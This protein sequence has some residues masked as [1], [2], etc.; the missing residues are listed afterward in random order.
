MTDTGIMKL[1]GFPPSPNTW[2]VRAV[3]A[4]LGVPI[5]NVLVDLGKGEQRAPDYLA[6]NPTG[7][8]PTL[9]DGD[10]VLWESAAIMQYLASQRPN[11]LWPDDV[12]TRADVMRWQSWHLQH[13]TAT[14][15]TPLL[16][17]CFVKR[18]F[19]MGAPDSAIVGRA[20]E[21][22][23]R[24]AAVLDR[25][26]STR[27]YLVGAGVTLADFTVVSPLVYAAEG[28]LPVGD[29]PHVRDWSARLLALPAWRDTAPAPVS[30]AA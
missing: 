6:L 5:E 21:A 17:E 14:A 24:E 8:T 9:V 10:F 28:E 22:F 7:R 25:H 13:W 27:R 26:L 15:C 19:N 2:K 4:H 20:T 1:Y 12:R 16:F 30:A 29:Y 18:F 23:R 11:A 3:A